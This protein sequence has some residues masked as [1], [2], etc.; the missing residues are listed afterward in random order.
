MIYRTR[1]IKV[2]N[3]YQQNS[4][5]SN[6]KSS[7]PIITLLLKCNKEFLIFDKPTV[8]IGTWVTGTFIH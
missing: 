6:K 2:T 4:N 8:V 7:N 1:K 3:K 5:I